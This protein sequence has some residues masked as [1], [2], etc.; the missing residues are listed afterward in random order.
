MAVSAFSDTMAS[1]NTALMTPADGTIIAT[2]REYVCC[3]CEH[4]FPW[5]SND[6]PQPRCPRCGGA[7]LEVNPW[8]LLTPDPDGLT[9][10]DHF[11]AHLSV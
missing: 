9:D 4:D 5:F 7:E 1:G 6:G 8:L 3:A 11:E 2:M 10:E